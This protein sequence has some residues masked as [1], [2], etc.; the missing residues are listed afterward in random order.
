MAQDSIDEQLIRDYLLGAL[1]EKETERLDEMAMVDD[2]FAELVDAV[3]NDLADAY[4]RGEI[5]EGTLARFRTHYL[6]SSRRKEKVRIA[7]AFVQLVDRPGSADASLPVESRDPL[8]F[9]NFSFLRPGLLAAALVMILLAGGILVIQ[10]IGLRNQVAER[11]AEHEV[12]LNRQQEL[13]KQL[14]REHSFEGHRRNELTRVQE[15]LAQLEQQLAGHEQGPVKQIAFNL[16][17][18]TRSVSPLPVLEVPAGTES[19]MLTLELE[20]NDFAAYRVALKQSGTEEILWF[21]EAV[22]PDP[23]RA[24]IRVRLPASV[25]KPQNYMAELS[26]NSSGGRAELVGAYPFKIAR[27]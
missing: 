2:E 16:Q 17:P 12:L 10:N 11:Q 4:V 21:S 8:V 23:V 7:E 14:D 26:G 19:V 6:A 25:L 13:Q 27:K 24:T 20:T 18:A 1:P 9:R 22:K 5:P 15:R 3:E